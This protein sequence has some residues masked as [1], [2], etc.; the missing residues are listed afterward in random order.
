MLLSATGKKKIDLLTVLDLCI[1][2]V[3]SLAG[4]VPGA[5]LV[6]RCC[7]GRRQCFMLAQG[8]TGAPW[9]SSRL[10]QYSRLATKWQK[11]SPQHGTSVSASMGQRP[12][13]WVLLLVH[14]CCVLDE[15]QAA[16]RCCGR[17]SSDHLGRPWPGWFCRER[18]CARVAGW[19]LGDTERG[20]RT[21]VANHARRS[22]F[23]PDQE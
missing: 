15:R 22:E 1:N 3:P 14:S 17:S 19:L 4:S 20:G 5:H 2:Y 8:D 10:A 12:V 21:E 18:S 13:C 23:R 9:R 11:V 16:H 6:H 7:M